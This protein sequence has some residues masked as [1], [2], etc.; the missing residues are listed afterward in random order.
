MRWNEIRHRVTKRLQRLAWIYVTANFKISRTS[1]LTPARPGIDCTL[2]ALDQYNYQ[3]VREFREE[4]RVAEYRDKLASHEIG[5]F[6]ESGGKAV[7][8][9]WA[10]INASGGP[11]VVKMYMKLMPNEALIHD[12]VASPQY[13]GRGIGP[14]MVSG[15]V[16]RLL[17]EYGV[18]GIIIDVDRRN[19]PSLRM[20]KK[21]GLKITEQALYISIFGNL[22]FQRSLWRDESAC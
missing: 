19:Q 9:I 20:M 10:S 6:A 14:F 3:R 11:K 17:S 2:V 12:I 13:K 18:A 4:N 22:V 16:E 1:E 21:V 8:S 15:I 7:G 5:Y